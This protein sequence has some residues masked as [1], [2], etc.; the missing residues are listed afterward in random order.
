MLRKARVANRAPLFLDVPNQID[1]QAAMSTPVPGTKFELVCCPLPATDTRPGESGVQCL[2]LPASAII[3]LI[4]RDQRVSVPEIEDEFLDSLSDT[5]FESLRYEN[6]TTTFVRTEC[7]RDIVLKPY[8]NDF[9]YV[10]RLRTVRYG[11]ET[12]QEAL[13]MPILSLRQFTKLFSS[14]MIDK[15]CCPPDGFGSSGSCCSGLALLPFKAI[16][17]ALEQSGGV[18][19]CIAEFLQRPDSEV[20]V[21]MIRETFPDGFPQMACQSACPTRNIA[22]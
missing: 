9:I 14:F 13:F 21:R 1:Q 12:T 7:V 15:S 5:E 3:A 6:K 18:Q 4:C 16:L 22:K 2:C 11:S 17:A 10:F 19:H 20:L 8:L